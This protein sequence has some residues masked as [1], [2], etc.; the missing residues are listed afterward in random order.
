MVERQL[1]Q[2]CGHRRTFPA[3]KFGVDG[4]GD[5]G[6]ELYS[7]FKNACPK[8]EP[9][10]AIRNFDFFPTTTVKISGTNQIEVVEHKYFERAVRFFSFRW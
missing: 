9:K 10:R 7:A 4:L 2:S 3:D 5:D 6:S 8:G 1:Y